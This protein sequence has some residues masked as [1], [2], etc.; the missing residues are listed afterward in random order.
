[1]AYERVSER[2]QLS[3]QT[4]LVESLFQTIKPSGATGIPIVW[5]NLCEGQ[6]ST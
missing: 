1:V 3:R 6:N 2:M 5:V 4:K